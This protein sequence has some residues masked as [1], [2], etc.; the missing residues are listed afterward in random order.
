VA[1]VVGGAVRHDLRAPV[2]LPSPK[3]PRKRKR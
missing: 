1:T 2:P 3:P